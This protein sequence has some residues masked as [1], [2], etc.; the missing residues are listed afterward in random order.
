MYF[1]ALVGE[2]YFTLVEEL[3]NGSRCLNP[4]FLEFVSLRIAVW[5]YNYECE[6]LQLQKPSI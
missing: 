5:K 6:S 2:Y 1:G 4:T 3:S